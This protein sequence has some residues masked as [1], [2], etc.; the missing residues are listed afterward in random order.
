MLSFNVIQVKIKHP[1]IFLLYNYGA[2][3]RTRFWINFT[4]Q[5]F[6]L[7]KIKNKLL[8]CSSRTIA[9]IVSSQFA[10]FSNGHFCFKHFQISRTVTPSTNAN[11]L[12]NCFLAT[13]KIKIELSIKH[14][15]LFTQP[16]N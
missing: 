12:M 2:I 11:M 3:I 13:K 8:F 1:V 10:L 4:L 14:T 16:K 15:K 6:T 5:N 9:M 7:K